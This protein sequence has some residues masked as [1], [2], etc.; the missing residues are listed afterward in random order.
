[1]EYLSPKEL[2]VKAFF[3]LEETTIANRLCFVAQLK[4]HIAQSGNPEL[5]F[6]FP[7]IKG[8][9]KFSWIHDCLPFTSPTAFFSQSVGVKGIPAH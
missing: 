3:F 1:M 6:P 4:M 5:V 2:I 7:K 9:K 8:S